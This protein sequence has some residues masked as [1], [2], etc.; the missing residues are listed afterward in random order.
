M[1]FTK[2]SWYSEVHK[3]DTEHAQKFAGPDDF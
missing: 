3:K 1:I 2:T